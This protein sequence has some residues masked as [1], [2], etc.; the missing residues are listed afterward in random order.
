[1]RKFLLV[2]AAIAGLYSSMAYG[3]RKGF[4]MGA[5]LSIG[6]STLAGAKLYSGNAYTDNVSPGVCAALQLSVGGMFNNHFGLFSG[7][8]VSLYSYDILFGSATITQRQT[9]LDIPLYLHFITSKPGRVGFFGRFG[10]TGNLLL[11]AEF[12]GRSPYA[13]SVSGRENSV[14][15]YRANV[16]PFANIGLSLPFKQRGD[17]LL[18]PKVMFQTVNNFDDF[19]GSEGIIVSTTFNVGF[20]LRLGS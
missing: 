1:M 14:D 13:S 16:S 2:T 12:D 19:E 18:G 5:D 7:V 20:R 17:L 3:Q 4:N 10:A 9:F 6:G 8:G 11:A 15:F